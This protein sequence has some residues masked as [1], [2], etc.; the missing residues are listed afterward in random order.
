MNS[1]RILLSDKHG[2]QVLLS[3][4]EI[5]VA[6]HALAVLRAAF[7]LEPDYA[8]VIDAA[9]NKFSSTLTGEAVEL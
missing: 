3:E 1:Q 9:R 5:G 2:H 7:D 6:L 4:Q 8:K